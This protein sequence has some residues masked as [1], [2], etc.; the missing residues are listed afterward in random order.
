M[1]LVVLGTLWD[2]ISWLEV[3]GPGPPLLPSFFKLLFHTGGRLY[4]PVSL[5]SVGVLILICMDSLT[6]PSNHFGFTSKILTL[7]LCLTTFVIL[8]SLVLGDKK[9][10]GAALVCRGRKWWLYILENKSKQV[11]DTPSL[12][13]LY[14]DFTHMVLVCEMVNISLKYLVIINLKKICRHCIL[15]Y[16]WHVMTF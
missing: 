2:Y 13:P 9:A 11:P 15:N 12:L 5:F 16:C 14:I 4:V 10:D 3:L 7:L 1:V 8:V 6:P